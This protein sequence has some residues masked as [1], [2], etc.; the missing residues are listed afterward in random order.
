MYEMRGC[1]N[2]ETEMPILHNVVENPNLH[3]HSLK[4][5]D[6]NHSKTAERILIDLGFLKEDAVT[7]YMVPS[8]NV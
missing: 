7:G 8:K 1:T 5:I 3:R 2:G 6:V 4:S